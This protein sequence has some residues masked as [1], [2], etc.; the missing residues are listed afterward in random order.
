MIALSERAEAD[1]R[2]ELGALGDLMACC[3][4][5]IGNFRMD[6]Y[7]ERENESMWRHLQRLHDEFSH[8]SDRLTLILQAHCDHKFVDSTA[9]LKCG[10]EPPQDRQGGVS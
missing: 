10:W 5:D 1:I 2:G 7:T 3:E 6:G 4:S 9:C 8:Q